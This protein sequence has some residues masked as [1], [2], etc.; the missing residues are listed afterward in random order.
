MNKIY[1]FDDL[2]KYAGHLVRGGADLLR[3]A[4]RSAKDKVKAPHLQ[5]EIESLKSEIDTLKAL[6]EAMRHEDSLAI[7]N[8]MDLY[9]ENEALRQYKTLADG[10]MDQFVPVDDHN[11]V[12]KDLATTREKLSR[13]SHE[14]DEFH[15]AWMKDTGTEPYERRT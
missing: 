1:N 13:V 10:H 15:K 5:A 4:H 3:Q 8:Y 11:K 9:A 14:L 12:K 2:K 6:R 7:K